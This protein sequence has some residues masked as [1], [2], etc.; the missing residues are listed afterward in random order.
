MTEVN[1][2][3]GLVGSCV[4]REEVTVGKDEG[5]E[6]SGKRKAHTNTMRIGISIRQRIA[7]FR[8]GSNRVKKRYIGISKKTADQVISN[9]EKP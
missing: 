1:I 8:G 7:Q 3:S 6:E 4:G 5:S 2:D 9:L